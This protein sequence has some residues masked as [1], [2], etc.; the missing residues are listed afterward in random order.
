MTELLLLE[1]GRWRVQVA[2]ALGGALA[3]ADALLP[4]GPAPVLRSWSGEDVDPFALAMNVL[5]PFSNRI[6]GGGFLFENEFHSVAPNLAGEPCPI[7]G[8]AFQR[9][10]DVTEAGVAGVQLQL[11]EGTIGPYHYRAELD[12]TLVDGALSCTL[13]IENRGPRLPFGGGFHPWFPRL[14]GTQ[15]AFHAAHMWLTDALHL[16]TMRVA[17]SASPEWAF[18]PARPLPADWINNAFTGWSG[19]AHIEQ[20]ELGLSVSVRAESS[21]DVALVYSPGAHAPFFCFEPVSH[22]VDAFDQLGQ[23]GLVVL[24]TGEQLRMS[25]MLRWQEMPLQ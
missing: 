7:H 6:S 14:S 24:D 23:P 17:L 19:T 10:W 8:D 18:N 9:A 1:D 25:V 4:K 16:P 13:Q 20:P 21:L 12:Y 5:A 3:S 2:P 11:K 22:P 15:L